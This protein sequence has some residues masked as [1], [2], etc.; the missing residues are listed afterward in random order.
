[1][2][3]GLEILAIILVGAGILIGSFLYIARDKT[4]EE[5]NKYVNKNYKTL[6]VSAKNQL[7]NKN[8]E[9][10]EKV[11]AVSVYAENYVEFAISGKEGYY[12]SK[13][14]KPMAHQNKDEDLIE[15]GGNKYKWNNGITNKI[16]KHWYY[17]R[18]S[19]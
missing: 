7:E 15:L 2:R 4:E 17:Y 1:M 18:V 12:Y 11:E 19:K 14:D 8:I 10:P 3:K 13:N 6:E 5:I 9:L 16:R